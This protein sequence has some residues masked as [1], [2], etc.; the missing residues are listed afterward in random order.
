[1]TK[2]DYELIANTLLTCR[3]N[4]QGI[5]T[6]TYQKICESFSYRLRDENPKFDRT[7]FLT[8]CGIQEAGP[9][10]TRHEPAQRFL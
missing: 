10:F 7:K 8:A 9:E 4:A 2:K 5:N 6:V 3:D 1:M